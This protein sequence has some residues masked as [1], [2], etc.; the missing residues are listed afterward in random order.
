MKHINFIGPFNRTGYGIATCGYAYGLI[1]AAKNSNI[2]VSFL[3]I[4][5]ID[6]NDPEINR[7]EYQSIVN[8]MAV[9]PI[10]E[11]PTICFWHLSHLS[12][13]L[14]Q[15]KGLKLAISTFETDKLLEPEL[16]GARA[17][18]KMIVACNA[19]KSVLASHGIDSKVIPHGLGFDSVPT[20]MQQEYCLAKWESEL[21]LQLKGYRVLSTV[22]KFEDRKGFKEMIEALFLSNQ[23][24]LLIGFLFNPFMEHGYPVKYIIENNWEPVVTSSGLKAY[25]KN[26]VILCMMPSLPTREQV[27]NVVRSSHA[28][29]SCSKAEGWNL[30][31][32]DALSLGLPCISTTNTAMA[33]YALGNVVDLSSGELEDANDGQF[34]LGNRGRWEKLDVKSMSKKIEEAVT[35]VDL[36]EL[37]QKSY[38][39]ISK[40]N[41][42][43][44]RLGKLLFDTIVDEQRTFGKE[45]S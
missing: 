9:Q 24:Y 33:D 4:G 21:G 1:K 30:P 35:K 27:Y 12:H 44:S 38:A 7:P 45:K 43:W 34:F 25:K 5:Q 32:F 22:G 14:G 8:C 20:P 40:L 16:Q 42:T 13:Y 10:W 11:E 3:P 18:H 36:T 39:N 31:L 41:Y 23:K 29:I 6:K 37:A 2:T 17:T 15:A 28:Y 19:N 26:N